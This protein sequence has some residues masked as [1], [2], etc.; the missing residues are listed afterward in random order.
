[1]LI[2]LLFLFTLFSTLACQKADFR[3]VEAKK[4]GVCESGE[5]YTGANFLF[6]VDN[7]GSMTQTDCPS[8][9]DKD[10]GETNREKAILS[11]FDS[12]TEAYV[13]S[14]EEDRAVSSVAVAKFTPDNRN[15]PFS[16]LSPDS[17][18]SVESYP[19]NRNILQNGLQ[20]TRQ[21][22]GDTPYLNALLWGEKFLTEEGSLTDR[23]NV[24]VLVTDGEPTDKSPS[25]VLEKAQAIDAPLITIR[26]NQEGLSPEQRREAHY[27]IISNQYSDW[28][29][30]TYDSLHLYVDDLM[31][32][33]QQIS[34]R[35]VIEISSVQDLE[36]RIFKDI[37]LET[38]PCLL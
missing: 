2:K 33:P 7:S 22:R 1:M 18:V 20:F 26:V 21:P 10:C 13:S 37:I 30:E 29:T 14:G 32:L 16:E 35:D 6:L 8:G 27:N 11:A 3:G 34:S 9:N 31:A 25:A 12:L 4:P 19:E 23:K 24:L 5:A 38:V 36:D 17:Y 28:P 15:Q